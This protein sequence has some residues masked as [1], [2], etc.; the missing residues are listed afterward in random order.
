MDIS[1]MTPALSALQSYDAG[2]SVSQT[3]LSYAV[4][5]ELLSQQLDMTQEM[6]TAM[7]QMMERSVTPGLGGNIHLNNIYSR[8]I[9]CAGKIGKIPIQMETYPFVPG[10][11]MLTYGN[12]SAYTTCNP[13]LFILQQ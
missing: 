1:G 11:F 13:L 2:S 6:G 12:R 9:C 3:S 4:S 10:F 8:I 5:T 7:V